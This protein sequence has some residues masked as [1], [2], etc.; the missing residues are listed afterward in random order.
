[1]SPRSYRNVL[2]S[3]V[4]LTALMAAAAQAGPNGGVVVGGNVNATIQGQGTSAVTINQ[5][6]QNVIINWQTFNLA[7]GDTTTFIQPNSSASALNRVIGGQGP[8][9]INGT[10]N[11]NGRVFIINGDGILIGRNASINTA[12]FLATTSNI[13]DEDFMAGR[14]NFNIPGRSDASIVNR[15]TITATNGGFAALVA[16]G[17]RNSGTITATLG[18]ISLA[19][20]NTFTLDFYGDR[21]IT[22][23]VNDQIA[24]Q[25]ID[26]ATGKPLKSLVQNSGKL[27][28][29][30]GRVELTAAA[31][32]AVVDSVINNRGVIEANSIGTH[33]GKIVLSAANGTVRVSGKISAAGKDNGTTGGTVVVTGENI[34]LANAQ[35]DASGDAGGGRVL[36]GGAGQAENAFPVPAATTLSVDGRSVIDASAKTSGDGGHIVL[37]SDQQTTFAGTILAQGGATGGN[38]GL[39]ETSG[40]SVDFNGGRVVT[41]APL[42]TT[43]TWLVDPTNLTIDAAAATTISTNLATT[44]VT[45]QTNADGSTSGPGN[46]SSGPGDIIV[47]AP[48]T[49]SSNA[50]LT[51]SAYH[52]IVLNNT[53]NGVTLVS[54]TGS[55]NLLLRADNTGTG[56]GNIQFAWS[57]HPT[58]IDF[59]R[60]A[61]TMAFYY[62]PTPNPDCESCTKYQN[63]ADFSV[64]VAANA[65]QLSAYMLINNAGDLTTLGNSA[66]GGFITGNYALGRNINATGFT[67]MFDVTFNG[68]LDGN[69]GLGTNQTISNLTLTSSSSSDSIGLLPFIGSSGIVRNLNLANVNITAGANIQ[70]IGALVGQN[71]GTISNVTV[72]SGSVNGGNFT[73]IGAGGLAGQNNAGGSISNSSADVSIAVGNS[74][75]QAQLNYAGGLVANNLGS[76]TNSSASSN[77]NGGTGAVIGGF[78]G[79]NSRTG[80]IFQSFATGP[81]SGGSVTGGFGGDNAGSLSQVF[82]TGATTGG[83]Q[84]G[85]LLGINRGSVTDTYATGAA[86]G[87][88]NSFTAGLVGVNASGASVQTSY[89]AGAVN[90]G[91]GSTL[92]GLVAQSNG[93]VFDSYWNTETS[94]Q[95]NSAGGTGMTSVQ[96]AAGLPPGFSSSVWT[97]LPDPS[98]PYFPWQN[99]NIP[100][101]DLPPPANQPTS[102][103]T[104][105]QPIV[106]NNLTGGLTL[107]SLPP[108]VN[109]LPFSSPP[110]GQPP[111]FGEPRLFALPPRGETRFVKDEVLVWVDCDAPPAALA[112]MSADMRLTITGMQCLTL[113]RRMMLRMHIDNGRSVAD[114]IQAMRRYQ[115][116]A[117]AQPHYKYVLTQDKT[118]ADLAG[119][120]QEGDA[121]QY[122]LGK[123]GVIDAHRLLKGTNIT[124]A[125]IDSEVDAHHPDLEGVIAAEYDAVGKEEAPHPHGTGMAGAIAAHR[126]LMGIAPSARLFTVHAFSTAAASAESTT[127]NILKGLDWAAT[128]GVRVVNMSFAGPRDP[129]IERAL[130]AAHDRGIV[131]IA[132]AGNA[133]P[134]SPPLFPGA[135]PNVIAVTATD[136]NDKVFSGANRG[137]Y[138]AVAAPGV[139]IL[140]PGTD[141][142]YQLTTGTSVACA[143]VSGVAALLLE[144][145]PNLTPEDVRKILTSSA[146]K[147]GASTDYG[148]GLVDLAKAIQE[149]GDLKTLTPA[150][151]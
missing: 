57:A 42:G 5:A 131:L 91:A 31:A 151:R 14:L 124:V 15:G 84:V 26:V 80:T 81:V 38:G 108:P 69:G 58:L 75:N 41:L 101:V 92:G 145:N 40:H 63:P 55:G 132:A 13:H 128:K 34:K 143:E 6:G 102:I 12:G 90:G 139:D 70:S 94:G 115:V 107:V 78:F 77:V 53:A 113:T 61:G 148:A 109:V 19:A 114:V 49:W 104:A 72:L 7:K 93:T 130:Q 18:T 16:P 4:A 149:A 9:F 73:G 86:S 137:G 74:P 88:A 27:S 76:I 66:S 36:I 140:V 21:L 56:G 60:S 100:T 146:K 106:I 8:S 1:M 20:A 118:E 97:I 52:S 87:G 50:T 89:S 98:F 144:R 150:R 22:L 24:G 3:T 39:V 10:L 135:N 123:L 99:G 71:S 112:A 35:I 125:V 25:V 103:P 83:N 30:G 51:L 120:T 2:A 105:S 11:A 134:K 126:R 45:L 43:G 138:I 46:T 64:N 122:V 23:A 37:W 79:S 96:L 59:S 136:I 32:R 133:G 121:A 127:F 110:A 67:G 119:L 147:L 62:N 33:D 17:V 29:N 47:L 95:T 117:L 142:G 68:L 54:N 129:S 116:V 28:A 82:A 44:S 65:G 48:I 141:G 85:G 111:V